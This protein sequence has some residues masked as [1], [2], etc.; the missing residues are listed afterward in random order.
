[1]TEKQTRICYLANAMSVHSLRWV[2]YFAEHGYHVELITWR[3]PNANAVIN[4]LV[5]LHYLRIPPH[6]PLTFASL[7]EVALLILRI[8]PDLIH[9]HYLSHFGLLGS[10]YSKLFNFKPFVLTEK[11]TGSITALK[12]KLYPALM[13][14]PAT[15]TIWSRCLQT[16][17]LPK[18]KS[19]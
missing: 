7:L 2:N 8:K 15:L 11:L 18:E 9:A 16:S 5:N 17:E 12:S 10:F 6:Y 13:S 3:K 1:M 19:N 14:S 4:P